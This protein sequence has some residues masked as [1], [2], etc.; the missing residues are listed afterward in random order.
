MKL[1]RILLPLTVIYAI[2]MIVRNKLYD[3]N[4]LSSVKFGK[5]VICVG[6]I[7][8]GGTG[9]TPF[10]EHLINLL[11]AEKPSVVSRGYRRKTKGLVVASASSTVAEI[12]DEPFQI[13]AKH[14]GTPLVVDADRNEAIQYIINN[15][16]SGVVLMDDGFQHRS[17]QAG[18]NILITDY[19]RPM[20]CDF[21]FP[22]GNLREP[23]I[24]R[25]RA[26]MI[27]VN[28]CPHN[29][30]SDEQ[31]QIV[32]KLNV[33]VPIFFTTI[34]YDNFLTISGKMINNSEIEKA[35]AVAGIGRPEPFFAEV[36]QRIADVKRLV[37][38][39]HHQFTKDEVE[40]IVNECKAEGRRLITTE[41][42][43]TRLREF[44]DNSTIETDFVVYLPIRLEV[45]F[46]E[47]DKLNTKI[48]QY[49]RKFDSTD[50]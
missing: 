26:Q 45:L 21:T 35:M 15:T 46:N 33:S 12:G 48:L 16:Q 49:V 3:W 37:F 4:V 22:A 41:K 44:V 2:V 38:A 40:K 10:I 30:T 6:N 27:V 1:R 8:V 50:K 23:W 36:E 9:K 34:V 14:T 31:K 17:T 47:A 24:G 5:P 39:D 20:W 43:A 42:D 18:C 19:A 32:Q 13:H 28:K 29:L 7:T 25:H 11:H